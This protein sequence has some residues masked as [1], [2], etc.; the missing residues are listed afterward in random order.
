MP[1][2]EQ[3]VTLKL[4]LCHKKIKKRKSHANK[5][6]KK[7]LKEVQKASARPSKTRSG[8]GRGE[9]GHTIV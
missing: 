3:T 9:R 8:K 5:G 1:T 4:A 6:R 7:V 2:R